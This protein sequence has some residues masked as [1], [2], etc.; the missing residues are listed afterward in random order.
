MFSYDTWANVHAKYFTI[1]CEYWFVIIS[2]LFILFCILSQSIYMY[3]V[4]L[5][6]DSLEYFYFDMQFIENL[7]GIWRVLDVEFSSTLNKVST[8]TSSSPN[9]DFLLIALA[10]PGPLSWTVTLDTISSEILGNSGYT[11]IPSVSF[12][13]KSTA[14]L[15]MPGTPIVTLK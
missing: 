7:T 10:C 15:E 13:I 12:T 11:N 3:Q 8:F 1:Q 6:R 9:C 2:F 4:F 14:M 5:Y